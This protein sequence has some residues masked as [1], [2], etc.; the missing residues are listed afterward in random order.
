MGKIYILK[1]FVEEVVGVEA[2]DYVQ[3][4]SWFYYFLYEKCVILVLDNWIYGELYNVVM[5]DMI[6]IIDY[7]LKNG[8]FIFWV[9]DVS[10]KYFFWKNGIVFVFEQDYVDMVVEEWE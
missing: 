8:Y 7:V 9:V 6:M 5:E 10:E 4:I 2:G 3:V 1:F